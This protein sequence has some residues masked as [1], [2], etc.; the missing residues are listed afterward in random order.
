MPNRR[1]QQKRSEKNK[2]RS[3]IEML[4]IA[5][6]RIQNYDYNDGDQSLCKTTI[7]KSDMKFH[8]HIRINEMKKVRIGVGSLR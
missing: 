2:K 6:D 4:R 5:A 3:K 7:M 8:V 1:L